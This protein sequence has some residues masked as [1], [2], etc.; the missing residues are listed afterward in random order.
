MQGT[1]AS[2]TQPINTNTDK[3]NTNKD[4]KVSNISTNISTSPTKPITIQPNKT[5]PSTKPL[6]EPLTQ[7][8]T[9]PA[10][11][12]TTKETTQPNKT[13]PSTKPATTTTNNTNNTNDTTINKTT[14]T[15]AATPPATTTIPAT[16]P[17]ITTPPA[18]TTTTTNDQ[19]SND[20]SST[21]PTNINQDI[22]CNFLSIVINEAIDAK[23]RAE[24]FKNK[25]DIAATLINY[26]LA[27]YS[28]DLITK[29]LK[30]NPN[31]S[32]LCDQTLESL[33][34]K[35]KEVGV[36]ITHLQNQLKNK[37]NA[38]GNSGNSNSTAQSQESDEFDCSMVKHVSLTG[39]NCFYFDDVVGLLNVKSEIKNLFIYP[40]IYPNL[41]P[42][43]AKGIL[44]YGLP[45]VGK[46]FIIKAAVN[47]LQSKDLRVIFY[48]P[49]GAELKG[50]Y[51]GESEKKIAAYFKC[52]SD[53]ALQCEK[54]G[55]KYLAVLF[56]DEI[57]AIGGDRNED[58]SG[59]MTNT[60][61]MLLQKMDGISALD[62][63]VVI[64][65]TN[66]PWKLDAALMR[67]FT[68][69][70]CITLP[71]SNDI[72]QLMLNQIKSY[73]NLDKMN[74]KTNNTNNNNNDENKNQLETLQ[75]QQQQN[76]CNAPLCPRSTT[77]TSSMNVFE[78]LNISPDLI[79]EYSYKLTKKHFSNSDIVRFMSKVLTEAANTARKHGI[80]RKIE[81]NGESA[82]FSTLNENNVFKYTNDIIRLEN[83]GNKFVNI[84]NKS[85]MN[86]N[87]IQQ[88]DSHLIKNF[89][90]IFVG[91]EFLDI[92]NAEKERVKQLG[93]GW[94]FLNPFSA[95]YRNS[96]NNQPFNLV[97]KLVIQFE[98][99]ILYFLYGVS[100]I[101]LRDLHQNSILFGQNEINTFLKIIL[102]TTD[103]YLAENN[104]SNNN[105]NNNIAN[106]TTSSTPSL[107]TTL[108]TT[109]TVFYRTNKTDYFRYKLAEIFVFNDINSLSQ[110][111]IIEEAPLVL[112]KDEEEY[113]IGT[114]ILSLS[115]QYIQFTSNINEDLALNKVSTI[116]EQ[117]VSTVVKFQP[118]SGEELYIDT[119]AQRN[120]LRVIDIKTKLK[121]CHISK[122]FF[123][124][125]EKAI[126][127][128]IKE[129]EKKFIDEYAKN[130]SKFD[131]DAWKKAQQET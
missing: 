72:Y 116:S 69:Q 121:T 42:K 50:K 102:N 27:F 44:L 125:A 54:T 60:V 84:D 128:T 48:A 118:F 51:V 41:Y 78:I 23:T 53:Q 35:Q 40:L 80:F 114:Q 66:F 89:C 56:I 49:T 8:L 64:A 29:F 59:L 85:Y 16:A 76:P 109:P 112:K 31:I 79:K 13:E 37:L 30:N 58:T 92:Q 67:R 28:Y 47:E 75:Q 20:K 123:D 32:T 1:R 3:D 103:F 46:T 10:T 7:S 26:T 17:A 11:T 98:K 5:E 62:N 111:F 107:T 131:V 52:A 96:I 9:K 120:N 22:F 68:N 86:V 25:G 82:Y 91:E 63:V 94:T 90:E 19:T 81:Y 55:Q 106:N 39:K 87:V 33:M 15:I 113:V 45:G 95:S 18:T 130:P 71:T 65:A 124:T 117:N 105:N 83:I 97:Y 2:V 122:E 126:Q 104:N 61:N 38:G 12:A 129:K 110:K 93:K 70:I 21:S 36:N 43:L 4:A 127:G 108:N 99:E 100:S 24:Q 115:K 77:S 88:L 34:Q 73:L 119:Y 14:T 57:E 6:T 101:N 74:A